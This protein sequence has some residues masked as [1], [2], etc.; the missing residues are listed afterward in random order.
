MQRY[1]GSSSVWFL[2]WCDH[3]EAL[4][5]GVAQ[6][7]TRLLFGTVSGV[8]RM[9]DLF[10]RTLGR[11]EVR[12]RGSRLNEP[13]RTFAA[14]SKNAPSTDSCARLALRPPRRCYVCLFDQRHFFHTRLHSVISSVSFS[15]IRSLSSYLLFVSRPSGEDVPHL[16]SILPGE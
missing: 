2:K 15:L 6:S 16:V 12:F 13:C 11:K 4:V 9:L 1:S 5:Y 10:S 8:Y 7:T 3:I 14:P